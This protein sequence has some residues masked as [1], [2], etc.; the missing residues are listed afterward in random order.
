MISYDR[1]KNK[2]KKLAAV[3]NFVVRFRALFI[4]AFALIVALITAFLCTKGMITN[5]FALPVGDIVYGESYEI[6]PA[7]A[8][9][10]SVGYE[11]APE[12][13]EEWTSAKPE[14]AGKYQVRTVT[15]KAFGVGYGKPVSFEIAPRPTEISILQENIVYGSDPENFTCSLVGGDK[16]EVVGFRFE[17]VVTDVTTVCANAESVVITNA[18]GEDVTYC[19]SLSTPVKEVRLTPKRVELAPEAAE[20][21]Y[22][23][24]P[25]SYESLLDEN[26]LMQLAAGDTAT[27]VTEITDKNGN[28]VASPEKAGDYTVT[29]KD[30]TILNGSTDVTA[31]Y[32]FK[33]FLKTAKI[34]VHKRAVTVTTASAEKVYD[35]TPLE[36]KEFTSENL[37]EGHVFTV[38]ASTSLV[39]AATRDNRFTDYAIMSDDGQDVTENYQIAFT[40]GVL[41]VTPKP[42]TVTT[43]S[44]GKKYDGTPLQT[45]G[46]T[47]DAEPVAGH[48]FA[49][50]GNLPS[51]TNAGTLTN[52]FAVTVSDDRGKS[53]IGNYAVSYEYGTLTVQKQ[54]LYY[55]AEAL[56]K[57]YDGTPL[58][59]F[60]TVTGGLAEGERA[61]IDSDASARQ[62]KAGETDNAP[63]FRIYRGYSGAETTENYLPTLSGERGKLTVEKRSVFVKTESQVFIYDGGDQCHPYATVILTGTEENGIAENQKGMA[64]IGD[65]GL[66]RNVGSRENKFTLEF[67]EGETDV[68]ENYFVS[69]YEYGTLTVTERYLHITTG[70]KQDVEYDGTPFSYTDPE[71]LQTRGDGGEN[72]G[73][74]EI[75]RLEADSDQTVASVT[76]VTVGGVENVFA[77]IVLDEEGQD[78]TRNYTIEYEYGFI[79]RIPRTVGLKTKDHTTVYDGKS[80]QCKE[81]ENVERLLSDLGHRIV[82]DESRAAEFGS[83]TYGYDGDGNEL[84][85]DNI[86]Y[87]KVLDGD[88]ADISYNYSL[89]VTYGVLKRSKRPMTVHT[90]SAEK[91][92]D[93]DYLYGDSEGEFMTKAPVFDGL[94][95]PDGAK[96][97][98]RTRV[99]FSV[100]NVTRGENGEALSVENKTEYDFFVAGGEFKTTYNYAL[101]YDYGTLLIKPRPLSVRTSTVTKVYDGQWL[102][103]VDI[104][105]GELGTTLI[106][107]LAERQS[108]TAV[109]DS[110]PKLRDVLWTVGE[111]GEEVGGLSNTT[112]YKVFA[113]G[114]FEDT[115]ANY[116]ITYTRGTLTIT[117]KALK[118][119]TLS[120]SKVYDAEPLSGGV[121]GDWENGEPVF[122]GL[123]SGELYAVET[124][125]TV[126]DVLR[127]EEDRTVILSRDNTTTYE[128]LA[129]ID[130]DASV[131][132]CRNTTKNYTIE[133][134]YGKLT[135]L[136]RKITVTTASDTKEYDGTPLTKRDRGDYFADNLV[137]T[138]QHAHTLVL[139]SA[140]E[141]EFGA[142]TD[143]M[144]S[145]KDNTLFVLVKDGETDVTNNYDISYTYGE[146]RITPREI[147]VTTASDAKEYD[148][149]PLTKR[150]GFAVV[151]NRLL[152]ELG[153]E[154]V[155]DESRESE[156][157][158]VTNVAEGDVD[159][160]LYFKVQLQGGTAE[161]NARVN[162]NYHI[163]P[164]EEWG[165]LTITAKTITVRT[166]NK[167]WTYDGEAHGWHEKSC[168]EQAFLDSV[169]DPTK[170]KH[171]LVADTSKTFGSVTNVWENEKGNN[172]QYYFVYPENH[173]SLTA[174]ENEFINQNYTIEYVYGDLVINERPIT[175]TAIT[176]EKVYDGA[177]LEGDKGYGDNTRIAIGGEGYATGEEAKPI[178]DTVT[179]VT[180]VQFAGGQVT[181]VVNGTQYDI[182]KDSVKTTENYKITLVPGS[183][184]IKQRKI[185][186]TTLTAEKIYD[187][188]PLDGGVG[189]GDNTAPTI[190][191]DGVGDPLVSGEEYEV[192]KATGVVNVLWKD[193]AITTEENKTTYR[194]VKA[195]GTDSTDNYDIEK[196]YGTLKILQRTIHYTTPT[197]EHEYD[198]TEFSAFETGYTVDFIDGAGNKQEGKGLALSTHKLVPVT[199]MTNPYSTITDVKTEGGAV[200]TIDNEVYYRVVNEKD[201]DITANYL[202]PDDGRTW[203][204]LKVTPRRLLVTTATDTWVYEDADKHNDGCSAAHL[205]KDSTTKT[206]SAVNFVNHHQI[207]AVTY[208]KV[209]TVCT[210][211]ENVCT[212]RVM[213]GTADVSFNYELHVVYGK[214]S[215]TARPIT[216]TSGSNS[217][218]YDGDA[219]RELT[220][221][222]WTELG[223]DIGLLSGHDVAVA[224]AEADA[225][226]ITHF[227][228]NQTEN[229]VLT[230]KIMKGSTDLTANYNVTTEYGT[231]A[232][233]KAE[234][235]VVLT[236]FTPVKYNGSAVSYAGGK[237]NY[238]TASSTAL[239]KSES[240]EVAVYFTKD[241]KGE[242]EH[243]TPILSGTYFAHLDYDNCRVY[244]AGSSAGT[245]AT[246]YEIT[247][248]PVELDIL[249]NGITVETATKSDV[250][251]GDPY[252]CTQFTDGT[253]AAL[254]AINHTIAWDGNETTRAQVTEVN[255]GEVENIFGYVIKDGDGKDVTGNFEIT[256][257]WGKISVTARS[258]TVVT[259]SQTHEYDGETFTYPVWEENPEG[260]L[261][262]SHGHKLEWDRTKDTASV[263]TVYDGEKT[264][265]FSVVVKNS[266]GK[267][268]SYN[269]AIAYQTDGK[270]KIT[271]RQIRV[272]VNS[273]D[274]TYDGTKLV[275]KGAKAE[276]LTDGVADDKA[277]LLGGDK[278]VA[279]G[280]EIS[281]TNVYEGTVV[282]TYAYVVKNGETDVS[283]N[284]Q[285]V[286]LI[287][288]ELK[289]NPLAVEVT[290]RDMDDTVYGDAVSVYPTGAGNYESLSVALAAGETLEVSVY[291][292][293][294]GVSAVLENAGEYQMILDSES[295]V[296][297]KSGTAT[298]KGIENYTLTQKAASVTIEKRQVELA[299]KQLAN[300]TK[301]YDGTETD[302]RNAFGEGNLCY[303]ASTLNAQTGVFAAGE[304]PE[305]VLSV[306]GKNGHTNLLHADGYEIRIDVSSCTVKHGEDDVSG[307]YTLTVT[308]D[309]AS[310]SITQKPFTVTLRNDA[311]EY[312]GENYEYAFKAPDETG[313][314]VEGLLDGTTLNGRFDYSD[315]ENNQITAFMYVGT[316]VVSFHTEGWT[317]GSTREIPCETSDYKLQSANAGTVEIKKRNITVSITNWQEQYKA[318]DFSFTDVH[319]SSA[320]VGSEDE[321]GFVAG[322]D[323]GQFAYT[324]RLSGAEVTPRNVGDYDV[325]V[326]FDEAL[327]ENY[328]ISVTGGTF[329]VIPR[330]ITVVGAHGDLTYAAEKLGAD[331]FSFESH[332][333][334]EDGVAG[335]LNGD[336]TAYTATYTV[337]YEDALFDYSNNTIHGG[338]YNADVR[339][340]VKTEKSE[341]DKNYT[342]TYEKGSFTILPR[343]ISA[344][345]DEDY[346]K[347]Y[348]KAAIK[349]D[350]WKFVDWY[351]D[352]REEK[353]FLLDS[354]RANAVPVFQMLGATDN[355]PVEPFNAGEY[356]IKIS[357][358]T[359]LDGSGL[360]E[361]DYSVVGG[362]AKLTIEKFMLIIKPKD[363]TSL[364]VGDTIALPADYVLT[365]TKNEKGDDYVKCT[366]PEGDSVTVQ[367][368][369]EFES[370][371]KPF[372]MVYIDSYEL[373]G[374]EGIEN[375]YTVFFTYNS[376]NADLLKPLGIDRKVWFSGIISCETRKLEIKQIIKEGAPK[377]VVTNG[378]TYYIPFDN[379]DFSV[380]SYAD[381]AQTVE[382]AEYGLLS[383]HTVK[384]YS[385]SVRREPGVYKE[386]MKVKIYSTEDG[387]EKDVSKG[388]NIVY[389]A[390][391]ESYF[392]VE[393]IKLDFDIKADMSALVNQNGRSLA[394][395]EVV[396]LNPQSPVLLAE[397]DDG[398]KYAESSTGKLLAKHAVKF[399]AVVDGGQLV[400]LQPYFYQPISLGELSQ[401]SFYDVTGCTI[402]YTPYLT[403]GS[404]AR[405]YD[406]TEL[407]CKTATASWLLPGH[408][409]TVETDGSAT[410]PATKT[411]IISSYTIQDGKG[412][413]VTNMYAP[414]K[415]YGGKIVVTPR[416]LVLKQTPSANFTYN[417]AVQIYTGSGTPTDLAKAGLVLEGLLPQH[418][419]LAVEG[420]EELLTPTGSGIANA[421]RITAI[422][423]NQ[424]SRLNFSD[425]YELVTDENTQYGYLN[426]AKREITVTVN[427][428]FEKEYDG[429]PVTFGEGN[430]SA[431]GLLTDAG[432]RLVLK[433]ASVTRP[434]ESTDLLLSDAITIMSGEEDVTQNYSIDCAIKN[435]QLKVTPRA[436][437][438]ASKNHT[439]Q[440]DG[441]PL[442]G[443]ASITSGSLAQ[444]DA[445]TFTGS[446]SVTDASTLTY[447]L[448]CIIKRG[449]EDITEDCYLVSYVSG[450]L[451]VTPKQINV[452]ALSIGDSVYGETPVLP[453]VKAGNYAMLSASLASGETLQVTYRFT[454]D[455]AGFNPVSPKD[456]GDYYLWADSYAV[457]G[458]KAE[459]YAFTCTP[460][461]FTIEQKTLTVVL[462]EGLSKEYDGNAFSYA[463]SFGVQLAY[464]G[465]AF[466]AT[467]LYNGA[468]EAVDAGEY[469]LSLGM[470]SVTAGSADVSHN[471]TVSVT[472]GH[473]TITSRTVTVNLGNHIR[474]Y[475]GTAFVYE[476][477]WSAEGLVGGATVT[478]TVVCQQDGTAVEAIDPGV[479]KL[480][481]ENVAVV[482]DSADNYTFVV[483]GTVTVANRTEAAGETE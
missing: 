32:D 240:L 102:S 76:D 202:I 192:V 68:T 360:I 61:E 133:Y 480:A 457:V 85:A 318:E 148:G 36:T 20:Y 249:P 50:T 96:E 289:I 143:V 90:L 454:S 193:G 408:T 108:A 128:L 167:D 355:D 236:P 362:E 227:R 359:S 404:A 395:G 392:T 211:V 86:L 299:I 310:Y 402:R 135:V 212:Y 471:Y 278:L 5:D 241:N 83:I 473:L 284:Y 239:C 180:D 25:L 374:Y 207:E 430:V 19:Y 353:G 65:E 23:G 350:G 39:D 343:E 383:G 204:T 91:T 266:A 109:N 169:I 154:L 171:V 309:C 165:K 164:P 304:A 216:I 208:T 114:T 372:Q 52:E 78:V 238:V 290:L 18:K 356:R 257:V 166:E 8:L 452:T 382:E 103:G 321:I 446:A 417:G 4:C 361:R 137:S 119:T 405:E 265:T 432:H 308:D 466:T 27:L 379:I 54:E 156:F 274:K 127:S 79:N 221:F 258:V 70:T 141:S 234:I 456:A 251:D 463:Y 467:V 338:T 455:A 17:G 224:T 225:P 178:A 423:P 444:G 31:L 375:N 292:T 263:Q 273:K 161:Q 253:I 429:T 460:S 12:G 323:N 45:D 357:G 215:I 433:S 311:R 275:E 149:T 30:V 307:N 80:M 378:S 349:T 248:S 228:D 15:D 33:D 74:V 35:G 168:D 476:D 209:N 324:F 129:K 223:K 280:D 388:Y 37:S 461:R 144:D 59:S 112:E 200:S 116:D 105:E 189:Y 328:N 66:I 67:Y 437:T 73:L 478:G 319:Y 124:V 151:D 213:D 287:D 42:I 477:A 371:T 331:G 317:V 369:G 152:T 140:Q 261:A 174:E 136:P 88:G 293:L 345:R 195:D 13:S 46:F 188:T 386:W 29:V 87:F 465:E 125:F 436:I 75:H 57:T 55:T 155:L 352:N 9:F 285:I 354:E 315:S 344:T 84:S 233:E 244:P 337:Y 242:G 110:I 158:T 63:V 445:L 267:D 271:P 326:D 226:S 190:T 117:P 459:N 313:Y 53:V 138:A 440:Y 272:T 205:V 203:G 468:T 40:A 420:T 6:Q 157:G 173:A 64:V 441:T 218:T 217:W 81:W 181:S 95:E 24:A 11:F 332:K 301:V 16:L 418:Q 101:T 254:Q 397:G 89:N 231:I 134:E 71:S 475:D 252:Y 320:H 51:I 104:G 194:I 176:A 99:P 206:D 198:G 364:Y 130:E 246:D 377:S 107:G 187:G 142:V 398:Y 448:G 422:K 387:V 219:H 451:D 279:T 421:V 380:V 376:E 339:L 325:A 262:E 458:G 406:G 401:E 450:T 426:V 438:F 294:N 184:T 2:I 28:V 291:F 409:L 282:N 185:K 38:S 431:A 26:S 256:E 474:E 93:G 122:E 412:N 414:A 288:G 283:E 464:A 235:T 327:S 391:E 390:D 197:A 381:S 268:I 336:E 366:L 260:L 139:D 229:N 419:Y 126:T 49:Q 131:S 182:Y 410:T 365:Y 175:I 245:D 300:A 94:A 7:K 264:N 322:D 368:N 72:S 472:E 115:T 48:V 415:K 413:D 237:D 314:E 145:P 302:Y 416:K 177:P 286:K 147:T 69:G 428:V 470:W 106:T 346:T 277:A 439:K 399:K 10:S 47:L 411:N 183:L 196:A 186:L 295:C 442:E 179:S 316:Y 153:H 335:F 462:P 191:W 1:Y 305:I 259:A 34:T 3:K 407:T 163:N 159:N 296:I 385:A 62:T 77:C 118:I 447:Q 434:S 276:H 120:A 92:Y 298:E 425:C 222:T 100:K 427:G 393:K 469:K 230:F 348:D 482:G 132:L 396:Y 384:I 113:D 14:K 220:G 312:N 443:D 347:V 403:A 389:R 146:L 342:I 400:G 435:I 43:A 297:Y 306:S 358:F 250:Y 111:D 160:V 334:G 370:G 82:L 481:L 172:V 97:I 22:G 341:I 367:G 121:K 123:V 98:Y 351:G 60:G 340:A 483:Y 255:E 199:D 214:L 162:A 281:V 330:E 210:D 150:D 201:E 303:T 394:N 21:T 373:H 424:G 449:G 58:Y 243:V 170:G 41:T 269:Y 333:T 270:I 247:A 232:I 479:Y 56:T 363:Y 453:T 329:S 44:G